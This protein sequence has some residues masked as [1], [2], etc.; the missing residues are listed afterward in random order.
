MSSAVIAATGVRAGYGGEEVLGPVDLSIAPGEFVALAGPNGSGKTTLLR[1]L[2]GLM[3][4]SQGEVRLFGGPPSAEHRSRIGFVPQRLYLPTDLPATV[5]EVVRLG[6]LGPRWWL[7]TN[8][9]D[10]EVVAAAIDIVGLSQHRRKR[11]GEL[12]GG[13]QQRV[14]IA[15]AL[16]TEPDLLILDEPTAGVDAGS[17][18]AFRD[19]LRQVRQRRDASILLVSHD[20]SAV[21]EDLDRILILKRRIVFDGSPRDLASRGVSLGLHDDDLPVWLEGLR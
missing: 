1:V 21:S 19:A 11:V 12:S 14:L 4:P 6:R 10:L 18:R 3:E 20:L 2:L 15:K 5:E 17:Q 7:R 9:H 8:S 13:Q 16:A